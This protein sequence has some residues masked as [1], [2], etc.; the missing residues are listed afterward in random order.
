V[1][2]SNITIDPILRKNNISPGIFYRFIKYDDK[3]GDRA[4]SV[5]KCSTL[6]NAI[7]NSDVLPT[8]RAWLESLSDKDF[9][10]R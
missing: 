7:T 5:E 6:Y 3:R 1:F 9:P 10:K 8:N 2:G 4:L